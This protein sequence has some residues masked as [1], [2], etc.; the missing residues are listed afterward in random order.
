MT[1]E[2]YGDKYPDHLLEQYKLYV[3]MTDRV[4]QRRERSNPFFMTLYW[5]V[6]L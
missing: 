1:P 3:E 5:Q 4:S 6:Q 2:E